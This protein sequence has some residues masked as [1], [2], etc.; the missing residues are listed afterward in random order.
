MLKRTLKVFVGVVLAL[1]L[2]IW[3][4]FRVWLSEQPP[5]QRAQIESFSTGQLLE[6]IQ[7]YYA[8]RPI[9]DNGA[10]G[11]TLTSGRGHAPWALRS[12]LDKR[13]RILSLALAP[14]LWLAYSTETASIHQYWKGGIDFSGAVYDARHGVE[15]MS[16]GVAFLQPQPATAWRVK[17]GEAWHPAQ[18]QWKGHGF[19]PESDALW[20]K[21]EVGARDGHSRLIT[22]WPESVTSDGRL[23]LERRFTMKPVPGPEVA[24]VLAT[25]AAEIETNGERITSLMTRND[26]SSSSSENL[27]VLNPA[28]TNL[29][30]WFEEAS[31]PIESTVGTDPLVLSSMDL[32]VNRDCGSCHHERERIVGPAWKEIAARY[33]NAD[34]SRTTELLAGRV[35]EGSVGEWGQIPMQAHPDLSREEATKLVEQILDT[36]WED[37]G[38]E[39]QNVMSK[40]WTHG[41]QPEPRPAT[42]HPSLS[43][44]QIQVAGF[45]PQVGGIGFLP[46]GRIAVATWDRDGAVFLVDGWADRSRETTA[47]RIAEGL[48]EPLGLAVV[49][50]NLYVLQKHE[51]TQLIDLDGDETIDEYRT[52]T[53][54]WDTTSNFHEFGFGLAHAGNSLYGGLSVCVLAGGDSCP[55]QLPDRG[56]IFR[57]SLETGE[58]SLIAS[59]L[60]TPNGIAATPAGEILVTDNQGA[61][62]PASKLIKVDV[63]DFYGW[64]AP[65]DTRDHGEVVP[66]ALWLPQNEIGNSPTQPLVLTTGPY[67]GQVLF[68]DIFNGGIKRASLEEVGGKL[69]GAA[70]H[71]S[72]GLTAPVHRLVEGPQGELVVGQIGS[73]GNWGEADKAWHGLE[74]LRFSN[75]VAFEPLTVSATPV[76]FDVRFSKP[77]GTDSKITPQ[78]FHLWQW[79]Y[80]PTEAYGGPKHGLTRLSVTSVSL[81]PDRKV[82]SLT[83]NGL[84]AEQVVYL[85]IDRD[86]RAND[87]DELWVNEAWYT[88]N[89]L[90]ESSESHAAANTLTE[91]ERAAGWRLLFDG[92]SFTGWKVYG[93][94]DDDPIEG[95]VIRDGALE[96]TRDVSFFGLILN[97]ANPFSPA[98][99]DLMTRERFRDFELTLE[100]QISPG[101]NSGIFYAVPDEEA[102]LSWT[103]GLEMQVL[104]DD[105]HS[106]GKIEKRRAGDL[107]DLATGSNRKARPVGEWNEVRI[108]V[109]DERIQHWLNGVEVVDLVRGSPQWDAA[110]AASKFSETEGFGTSK[111]GHILLQD[112]GDLVRYRNIKIRELP[113]E[114]GR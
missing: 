10:F 48:H 3:A 14:G 90:P 110:V 9:E 4:G 41:F 35:L 61:W 66:P 38:G 16:H 99:L 32:L 75:D 114:P 98:A 63:G 62:L 108:R 92:T 36:P 111:A 28:D 42:L 18:I 54:D 47:V 22:E 29:V 93:T 26:G 50:A 33:A 73:R 6:F 112:H 58:L 103:Y 104:D 31:L 80:R 105:R 60:R 64:R 82:A 106:D 86:V 84:R 13:P 34:T 30:E 77:L 11:R 43:A 8:P 79:E 95:W 101:G 44:E 76:G 7:D 102:R 87:G 53:N 59:G 67:K 55:E 25:T 81:S 71:F 40:T 69:Q 94:A 57:F 109:E 49:G 74:V 17:D 39:E 83:V 113:I 20:L 78:Q 89:A 19:D 85:H 21:F 52:L 1:I 12:S 96:F 51:L 70:F 65:G 23:G 100:W 24:L 97:H 15:P 91:A 45:T 46:D 72:G 2:L 88:M 5:R 56:K 37:L 107:Y 27:L 68:G